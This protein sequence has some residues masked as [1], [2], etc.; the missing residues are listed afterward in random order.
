MFLPFLLIQLIDKSNELGVES[1]KAPS[2]PRYIY[3][4][5]GCYLLHT[6]NPGKNT[7]HNIGWDV[8][9]KTLI[10]IMMIQLCKSFRRT[11]KSN[12]SK[13]KR[14][15]S[16]FLSQRILNW[17]THTQHNTIRPFNGIH[18]I[19]PR[20]KHWMWA[21]SPPSITQMWASSFKLVLQC[22]GRKPTHPHSF[23]ERR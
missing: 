16:I 23:S 12:H 19:K 13:R 7:E 15:T 11:R 2:H 10:C 14:A 18:N 17:N 22:V 9:Q 20:I 21:N 3:F 1:Q 8:F 5:N 4:C 6:L